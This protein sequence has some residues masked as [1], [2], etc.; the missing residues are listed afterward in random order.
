[1]S[2]WV[3]V[4]GVR[5]RRGC[6][7]PSRLGPPTM[8]HR[9]SGRARGHGGGDHRVH[10]CDDGLVTPLILAGFVRFNCGVR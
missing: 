1:M 6:G 7:T 9:G 2:R 10:G 3:R 5:V 8:N 4:N